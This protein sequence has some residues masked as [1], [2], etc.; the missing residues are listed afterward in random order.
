MYLA[1]ELTKLEYE[2]LVGDLETVPRDFGS[3]LMELKIRRRIETVKIK[4]F[5]RYLQK[6]PRNRGDCNNSDF[7][8]R[9]LT[10]ASIIKLHRVK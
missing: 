10:N 7:D 2:C 1:G 6:Y 3:R 9:P 8:K 5:A 4:R